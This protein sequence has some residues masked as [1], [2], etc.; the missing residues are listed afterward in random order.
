M[1]ILNNTQEV[2]SNIDAHDQFLIATNPKM[3]MM[4]VL[5]E[6]N[7][8]FIKWFKETIF[9][10]DTASKTLRLLVVGQ[11]SMSHLEGI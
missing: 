8:S 10:D 3:N 6:H 5:Q 4:K 9:G 1:Y 11:I 2:L 7:R